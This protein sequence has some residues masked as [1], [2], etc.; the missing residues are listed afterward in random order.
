MMEIIISFI[1]G[2]VVGYLFVKK[3]FKQTHYEEIN[4]IRAHY[5]VKLKKKTLEEKLREHG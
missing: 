3:K 4:N 1:I 5:E 2:L